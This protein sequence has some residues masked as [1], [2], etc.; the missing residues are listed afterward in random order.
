M[1]FKDLFD[2]ANAE[3]GFSVHPAGSFTAEL[4]DAKIDLTKSPA[5]ITLI[6]QTDEGKLFAN[7]NL[8][9]QGLGILKRDMKTLELDYSN[10]QSEEDIAKLFWD[11]IAIAPPSVTVDVTH[12]EYQGKTYANVYLNSLYKELPF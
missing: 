11:R 6:Y 9:G 10:V 2:A 12:R 5:R 8:Q 1:S 7:Y 3:G 4:T